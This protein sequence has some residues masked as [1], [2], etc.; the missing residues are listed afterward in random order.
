MQT[1]TKFIQEKCLAE[2]SGEYNA[3]LMFRLKNPVAV[4]VVIYYPV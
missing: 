2:A 3:D 1:S 4:C